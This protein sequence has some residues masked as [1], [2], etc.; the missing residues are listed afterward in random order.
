MKAQTQIVSLYLLILLLTPTLLIIGCSEDSKEND[1][2]PID[3]NI[4]FYFGET[5]GD[6][7]NSADRQTSIHLISDKHYNSGGFS[8]ISTFSLAGEKIVVSIEGVEPPAPD[9][10]VTWDQPPVM[11]SY[12]FKLD[13]GAYDLVFYCVG[14]MPSSYSLLVTEAYFEL[15]AIS[16]DNLVT[17]MDKQYRY[18]ENSMAI[19]GRTSRNEIN[20]ITEFTDRL[21]ALDGVDEITEDSGFQWPYHELTRDSSNQVVTQVDIFYDDEARIPDIESLLEVYCAELSDYEM[22]RIDIIDWRG[23]RI[24]SAEY[25]GD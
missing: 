8:L 23:D 3:G 13:P 7:E 14:Y 6:I 24:S 10:R 22:F 5:I 9:E 1:Y 20:L 11:N 25:I 21:I 12:Q 19:V 16:V 18:P 17:E 15:S 4:N 2:L